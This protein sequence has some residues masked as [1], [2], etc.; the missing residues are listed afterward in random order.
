MH[1]GHPALN[2]VFAP[3][4]IG[5]S[6]EGRDQI[7]HANF[8]LTGEKPPGELTLLIGGMHGDE[9]ATVLL[10]EEFTRRFLAG[11]K[12]PVAVLALCNP[13]SYVRCSRYNARGVDL[14]RNCGF[15]WSAQS[16]EPSGPAPWSEPESQALRDFILRWRPSKIVSLHWALAEIDAD[17]HQSTGL[18]QAMWDALSEEERRP[19]RLR[20]TEPGRGQK[21]LQ[22]VYTACPG[23]LGQWC[24]YAL[25]EDEEG[26]PAMITLELP[27]DPLLPRPD[28]LPEDH[29][30]T[31]RLRWARDSAGYLR[32]AEGP[33]FKMLLAACGGGDDKAKGVEKK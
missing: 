33:V 25:G 23:S 9:T 21:R 32:E 17:G 12:E 31:L 19:Y 29:L 14:N 24:G 3:F 2:R 11:L 26:A 27:Y 16:V 22:S 28:D 13:D 20:V 15:N 1:K 18:A 8:D 10:L 7:I 4:S 6:V 30:E 5:Q